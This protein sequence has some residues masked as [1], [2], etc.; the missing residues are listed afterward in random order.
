MVSGLIQSLKFLSCIL[1]SKLS[2]KTDRQRA[3]GEGF[4]RRC[5][6]THRS[7]ENQARLARPRG[8]AAMPRRQVPHGIWVWQHGQGAWQ[9]HL[10]QPKQGGPPRN[11]E[12]P[13][14]G[15]PRSPEPTVARPSVLSDT[16]TFNPSAQVRRQRPEAQTCPRADNQQGANPGALIPGRKRVPCPIL[17]PDLTQGVTLHSP[18]HAE[19]PKGGKE[20]GGAEAG[21]GW[22]AAPGAPPCCQQP[23]KTSIHPLRR[24]ACRT[25]RS[26]LES[27]GLPGGA[28]PLQRYLTPFLEIRMVP[29][30]AAPNLSVS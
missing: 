30:Q 10:A 16:G 27:P 20:A 28:I 6:K 26:A 12:S 5:Q 19:T 7:P 11:P 22:R 29:C 25:Y 9:P 2:Q 14:R 24:R 18:P 8:R 21:G 13:S 4:K 17:A 1:S 23:R 3:W 15:Q